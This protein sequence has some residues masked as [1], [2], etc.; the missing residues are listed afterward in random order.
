MFTGILESAE[1]ER[2]SKKAEKSGTLFSKRDRGRETAQQERR[3][4]RLEEQKQRR[5][6][7]LI[8]RRKIAATTIEVTFC[9][10]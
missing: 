1:A 9:C 5:E 4:L 3:R 6:E 7:I 8:K 10:P 2:V